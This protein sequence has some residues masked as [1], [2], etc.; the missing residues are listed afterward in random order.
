MNMAMKIF[1]HQIT[2]DCSDLFIPH[3]DSYIESVVITG[4]DGLPEG[5]IVDKKFLQ[6]VSILSGSEDLKV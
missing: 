3:C 1:Q 4:V 2:Y 6:L 5:E